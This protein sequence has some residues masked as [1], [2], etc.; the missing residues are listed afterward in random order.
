M[1][2]RTSG[3]RLPS[4]PF[5]VLSI[6]DA[7]LTALVRRSEVVGAVQAPSASKAVPIVIY[8]VLMQLA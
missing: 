1:G 5:N 2:A 6:V 8:I 3:G 4:V 7:L